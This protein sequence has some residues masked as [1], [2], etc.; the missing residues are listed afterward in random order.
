MNTKERVISYEKKLE[1]YTSGN[2]WRRGAIEQEVKF[3]Q[4]SIS[5]LRYATDIYNN[6]YEE[7]L[8][9][10]LVDSNGIPYHLFETQS[11]NANMHCTSP[12][13]LASRKQQYNEICK[14]LSIIEV[15]HSS[16]FY[17]KQVKRATALLEND[18]HDRLECDDE[19]FS[20]KL[21]DYY[22]KG[23]LKR[24]NGKAVKVL[25]QKEELPLRYYKSREEMYGVINT[26][27][28]PIQPIK[29]KTNDGPTKEM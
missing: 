25:S 11:G 18:I 21:E 6:A 24:L 10:Y 14:L 8:N 28:E 16:I 4:Y 2:C 20:I 29:H 23:Q 9:F 12:S 3:G 1:D 17:S 26:I 22:T 15:V 13:V 27:P 5:Q 7:E 19:I